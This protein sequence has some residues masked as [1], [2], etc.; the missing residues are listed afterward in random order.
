MLY[1]LCMK[2]TRI[3][4]FAAIAVLFTIIF[5]SCATK[6]E[7][8][9]Q[10]QEAPEVVETSVEEEPVAEEVTNDD[11]NVI[12]IEDEGDGS[13]DEYLR[14]IANLDETQAVTKQEFN[15]DKNEIL[16]IISELA[17][18]METKDTLAWL[19]FIDEESKEYYKNPVN[20][21][22]AQR[23]LPNKLIELKTIE[24]YFKSVFIPARRNSQID[25][26][27]YISKTHVK[28]VQIR[29]DMPDAIYYEFKKANGK[30]LVYIP[31]VS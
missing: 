6:P 7:E 5:S 14:S 2:K 21:R 24:D 4:T 9:Q 11:D 15:D 17:V 25:E 16:Q 8:P 20:L 22:K 28:A 10:E 18:I 29:E 19:K 26:I 12:V 1:F 27:R 31:P 13:D 30:W 3:F 23:K